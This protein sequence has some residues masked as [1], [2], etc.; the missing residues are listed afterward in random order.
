[1]HFLLLAIGA[2]AQTLLD[3]AE[4]ANRAE[5]DSQNGR[6]MTSWHAKLHKHLIGNGSGYDL[7]A[8]PVSNRSQY[9]DPN[10]T[11]FSYAAQTSDAGTDVKLQLRVLKLDQIDI[12]G[13]PVDRS[14]AAHT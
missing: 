6:K 7:N 8:P 13:G 10:G 4:W 11:P 9:A 2:Q 3:P 1:M 14:K 12:A 5:W